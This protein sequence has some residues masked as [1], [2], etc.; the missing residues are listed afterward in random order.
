M[1]QEE[2]FNLLIRPFGNAPVQI[3]PESFK[4]LDVEFI[5]YTPEESIEIAAPLYP[6]YNNPAGTTLGGYLPVFFDL[7][8]GPLS[9]LVAKKPTTTLE[10][11]TSYHRPISVKDGKIFVKASVVHKG[12]SYLFLEAQAFNPD[13][14]LVATATSRLRILDM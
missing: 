9:F 7:A 10:L 5:N 6:K 1:T 13:R 11:N 3:P 12:R 4:D 14:K 2:I 8:F